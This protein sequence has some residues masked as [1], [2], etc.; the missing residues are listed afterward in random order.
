MAGTMKLLVS[1]MRDGYEE[2]ALRPHE[3]KVMKLLGS[4]AKKL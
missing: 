2:Y 3:E 4:I 1:D